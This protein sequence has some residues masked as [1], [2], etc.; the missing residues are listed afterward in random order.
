MGVFCSFGPDESSFKCVYVRTRILR[1]YMI[2][3]LE[4]KE[5][6]MWFSGS[7]FFKVNFVVHFEKWKK[8]RKCILESGGAV[9]IREK[10]REFRE[11]VGHWVCDIERG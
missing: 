7:H 3:E 2:T 6:I 9:K 4:G 10:R 5:T 8:L 1:R 11:K